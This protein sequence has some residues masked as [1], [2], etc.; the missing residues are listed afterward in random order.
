MGVRYALIDKS[1]GEVVN[2][3]VV[4][5]QGTWQPP[6]GFEIVQSDTANSGDRHVEGE[7]VRDETRPAAEAIAP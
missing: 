7:F 2:V 6:E 4:D 3:I 5:P 1:S